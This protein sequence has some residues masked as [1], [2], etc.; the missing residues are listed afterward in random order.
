M[1]DGSPHF[2][3][4][5]VRGLSS[6]E[7][8]RRLRDEGDNSLPGTRPRNPLGVALDVV[9]EPMLLLLLGAGGL[10]VVMGNRQDAAILL[11]FVVVV[12]GITFVQERRTERALAALRDLASPRALV[13]RDGQPLR[14]AGREVVRGDVVLL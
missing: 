8:A 9:R 5:S 1:Q 13:I 14:V 6:V 11:S 10:Y 4:R 12:M 2:D 7:A 3:L